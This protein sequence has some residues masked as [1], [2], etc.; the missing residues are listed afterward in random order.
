MF[1]FS[2]SSHKP[3]WL[4]IL[5]REGQMTLAHVV[6]RSG[7]RPE[8][9]GLDTF[10]TE[11]GEA[12]ERAALQRLKSSRRL[13]S[14][15][16]TT[17]MNEGDYQISQFDAPS[18]PK[19]ER[20]EALRWSL[21]GL[22]DYPVETA[23]LGVLDIPGNAKSGRAGGVLLVSAGEQAVRERAAAFENAR[24][25]LAAIDVPDLAQ[26]NV[27]ALLEDENRGLVFLHL[28][29]TGNLLTLT[30][31]GELVALRRGETGARQ[32][33]AN[34]PEK[35]AGARERLVLDMQ[36]SLDNYD[37][38][39]SH[40]S[41]SKVILAM[42]TPVEGLIAG[43]AENIYV[44]VQEMDLAAAIDFPNVPELRDPTFQARNLL[45]IGAALRSGRSKA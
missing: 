40:I 12:G 23:C 42:T 1:S 20:A 32:M 8:I 21:R 33:P 15:R 10:A 7:R 19:E 27:A 17:L 22:V 38:Q 37:R 2:S 24:V 4:A 45:A 29:E 44:P 5:S 11:G 28:D 43:L 31:R 13:K 36:R 26:R 34:D 30:Y 25:P 14:F 39:Y 3:G 41:V 16:C 9:V 35:S 6:H 18:V